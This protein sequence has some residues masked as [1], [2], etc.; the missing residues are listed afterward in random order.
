MNSVV[1]IDSEKDSL[2]KKNKSEI[3][4][5]AVAERKNDPL[6][7]PDKNRMVAC[8]ALEPMQGPIESQEHCPADACPAVKIFGQIRNGA[9]M[10]V[11][12]RPT[13]SHIL[14]CPNK[15]SAYN[16]SNYAAF[17]EHGPNLS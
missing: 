1:A 12:E 11:R 3:E 17:A 5:G 4:H 7:N 2:T 13:E 10:K 14:K 15:H 9:G 16:Q 6:K 8:T